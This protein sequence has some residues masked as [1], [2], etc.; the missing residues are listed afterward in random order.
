MLW[1]WFVDDYDIIC[2]VIV[3]VVFGCDDYNYKVCVFDGF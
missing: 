2:D 1:E 3:V